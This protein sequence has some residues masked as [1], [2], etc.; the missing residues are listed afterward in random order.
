MLLPSNNMG[1]PPNVPINSATRPWA[2]PINLA[3]GLLRGTLTPHPN[4]PRQ[5]LLPIPP[6]P[7]GTAK[8]IRLALYGTIH[9]YTGQQSRIRTLS[10]KL[11]DQRD[12]AAA[13]QQK[14][15]ELE[16]MKEH[17]L[18]DIRETRQQE[19]ANTVA[20]LERKLRNRH[21]KEAAAAEVVWKEHLDEECE[22][23][24]KVWQQACD[25]AACREEPSAKRVKHPDAAAKVSCSE[26]LTEPAGVSCDQPA[27]PLEQPAVPFD[28][29]ALPLEQ[30]ALPLDQPGG[31]AVQVKSEILRDQVVEAEAAFEKLTESRTEM[32]WLLK[33]V[34]KAEEKQKA[35][36]NKKPPAQILVQASRQ[37]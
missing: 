7:N 21:S 27:V 32:I 20:A 19:T 28:Q 31:S 15:A 2:P 13:C 6:V 36:G 37:A 30:I 34:I 14:I 33:Q 5:Y 29:P 10:A 8:A 16:T 22:A 26:E 24:R 25:D 23:K 18:R 4:K 11:Q 12:E 1:R 35:D 17:S 3:G 9:P